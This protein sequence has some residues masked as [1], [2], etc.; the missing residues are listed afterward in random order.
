METLIRSFLL[1]Q[2]WVD[3]EPEVRFLAAGEYNQNFLVESGGR[4]LV[5]RINHGSQ[6][7]LADQIGY[8][9]NALRCVA[10]SGVTPK[11]LR[12][13][14]GPEPFGGGVMLMEWLPGG[15]LDYGRDLG[16]AA[17]VFAR[18]H[19]L[20]PCPGLLTQADPVAAIAAESLALIKR[21]PGQGLARQRA[22]LL[23]YHGR[24]VRLGEDNRARFAADRPCVVNT[25]VNSGNFLVGPDGAFLVDWEK[26]VV[27]SRHQDLGHFLAPTTTLWRTET[28][29][30]PE[31]KTAFLRAYHAALP[32]APPLE[33]L[34][35]L[36][37][38]MERAVVLRGLSWC[39]M[40]H[41]E[42]EH[43][44]RTLTSDLTRDRIRLYMRDMG[45]IIDSLSGECHA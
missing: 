6:L 23:D 35:S 21:Y 12:V 28:V 25:E 8:E 5:F 36:C 26:A 11:P 43:A 2:G 15:P 29:L 38:V 37:A 18:V 17:L 45:R 1:G 27:S 40:A 4:R 3:A 14:A 10:P 31:R 33:E 24:I 7:G 9:F 30:A 13:H 16:R 39:F 42:Y 19:A 44:G 32:D 41:H 22:I 34:L 20:P